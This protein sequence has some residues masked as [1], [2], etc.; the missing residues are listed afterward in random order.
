MLQPFFVASFFCWFSTV[1]CSSMLDGNY[2]DL[3]EN[4]DS[5]AAVADVEIL[6]EMETGI[7]G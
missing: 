4:G 1:Y 5:D 7:N 6:V 2:T 3:Q